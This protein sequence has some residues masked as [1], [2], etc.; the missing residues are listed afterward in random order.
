MVIP[1]VI[2]VYSRTPNCGKK[3]LAT[4]VFLAYARSK[5]GIRILLVDFSTTEKLRY[6]LLGY[7]KS[8]FTS[9]EFLS[10]I[11]E[12]ILVNESISIFEDEEERSFVRVLPSSGCIVSQTGLNE[13]V[14]Y[15]V[16][17]LFFKDI[18]D[19]LIF[20]LPVGLEENTISMPAILQSDMVWI[21]SS[22]KYPTMS[23]TKS[24]ITNFLT[25]LTVPTLLI[26][27]M[28]Q[29]PVVYNRFEQMMEQMERKLKHPIF[30]CI[31]WFSELKEFS[32]K[33]IFTLEEETSN[34]NKL[35]RDLSTKFQ[36]F[37]EKED[38]D[39]LSDEI[40]GSPI[41]L[42]ITDRSSGST[43][44]YYFFGKS[45]DEM[46]NPTLITAALTSIAH[47][48]SETAGRRGDLRYIDNGNVKI[49]QRKGKNVIGI[50]YSPVMND[51]LA[52]LLFDFINRFEKDFDNS[53]K[54]FSKTGRIGGFSRATE[55]VEEIF[56]PFVFDVVTVSEQL[57]QKIR[58]YGVERNLLRGASEEL[59]EK[60]VKENATDLT[61][62]DLLFYEFTTSHNERHEFLLEIGINP[63][64]K[65]RELEEETGN[66]ICSCTE[67]PKFIQIQAFDTLGILDLP[68]KLRPTARALLTSKV[69]SPEISAELTK[70]DQDLELE[71]LEELRMRGYVK[72]VSPV[73]F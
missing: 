58:D 46:K 43:M 21:I 3:T 11:S 71:C 22:E 64:F 24:T 59:F 55:I 28:V 19:L 36:E 47:M 53:I 7:G 56:E 51:P 37:T 29:P 34:V 16:N 60:Y 1:K 6:S 33:G 9:V 4:N 49:V 54:E 13:R 62:R 31:P 61:V 50:L 67:P 70:R 48:V 63:R 72:R 5:P 15:R 18:I 35:F 73:R 25:F 20:V 44:Y 68:E 30:Y 23:L 42:F 27:N 12:D 32:D 10:E 69:L 38:I 2:S 57:R 39:R 45:E 65:Q 66:R 52:E 14:K 41:A 40:D 17:A 8:H 26:M